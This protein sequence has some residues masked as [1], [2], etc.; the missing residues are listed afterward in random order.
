MRI[1][2]KPFKLLAAVVGGGTLV[3]MGALS[4]NVPPDRGT[5]DQ[6]VRTVAGPM[7]TGVTITTTTAPAS[8]ATSFA[9][10]TVKAKPFK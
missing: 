10:P 5:T 7:Q 4:I 3:I 2:R 9:A 6:V 8:L 1:Q